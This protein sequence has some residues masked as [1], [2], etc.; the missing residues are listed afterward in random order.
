MLKQ[1]FGMFTTAV[2]IPSI[3]WGAPTPPPPQ[4]RGALS[5]SYCHV[6]SVKRAFLLPL[7]LPLCCRRRQALWS[8][9][10]QLDAQLPHR[11]CA[12]CR[13]MAFLR[14]G[15]R[16][17]I[18]RLWQARAEKQRRLGLGLG[19]GQGLGDLPTTPPRLTANGSLS[20]TA[21][22]MGFSMSSPARPGEAA[23]GASE[24]TPGMETED[25]DRDG[26]GGG[27][28]GADR[29]GTLLVR[30]GQLDGIT[31]VGLLSLAPKAVAT[32]LLEE[33]SATIEEMDLETNVTEVC[34]GDSFAVC[35][36]ILKPRDP[37]SFS[38]V[39]PDRAVLLL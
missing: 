18:D 4:Q 14:V 3:D 36:F 20:M 12:F 13:R 11:I 17:R 6:M 33:S 39:R 16:S 5:C 25:D 29:V 8:I 15:W 35:G 1:A 24:T 10:L 34:V 23:A 30:M 22:E 38:L 19:L 2:C 37:P 9:Q 21:S 7:L 26:G 31:G 32:L 28:D 27:G